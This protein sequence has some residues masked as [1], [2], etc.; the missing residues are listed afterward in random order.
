MGLA[1]TPISLQGA[2]RSF[3]RSAGILRLRPSRWHV[4][5]PALYAAITC[6]LLWPLVAH[7]GSAVADTIG[8]P[9]LNAWTLRW[10]QHAVL[11]DPLRLY[12]GNM[13][14]PNLRSLAFSELL[15]PQAI[16][17]WPIW[18]ITQ[19]V[20]IAYNI[21]V[22]ITYP[23]CAIG[24][25]AL[26]RGLG[27]NRG[28]AFVAG[29]CFSFAPFRLDNNAHLQVLSMQWMPLALLAVVRFMQRPT[30]WR[31]AAVTIS[32]ALTSLSSVYYAMMFGTGLAVFLIIEA[33]RQRRL[34]VSRR[35]LG[36]LAALTIAVA[37]VGALD[38]PY[39]VMRREQQITRTLDEAYDESAHTGS[40]LTVTPGNVAWRH[41]LPR[42]GAEHTALF[43][44]GV[45]LFFAIVG[46]R[47]LRRPWFA[48][49]LG[50]GAAC[51]VLSFG[52]TLG[53]KDAGIPLPYRLLYEYVAGFQGI[54][55]P[56]RF[57]ALVLLALGVF[58][59]IG[60]TALWEAIERRRPAVRRLGVLVAVL[61]AAL[62]VSDCAARLLPTVPV[63]L[64]DATLAPYRWL[65]SQPNTGTVAEFPVESE[66]FRTAFYS[67]YHWHPLL[68]GH[69][70]FVPR[71]TYQLRERFIKGP[72]YPTP[73]SLDAL[74]DFGV[75]TL[76][77][78]RSEYPA[79]VLQAM[80][81]SLAKSP[82]RVALV[83]R[84]G[85][86][87]IYMLTPDPSAEALAVQGILRVNPNG[88]SDK[89]PGILTIDN[90]G[91]GIRMLYVRGYFSIAAEVRD[92]S[93]R[94]LAD[95]PVVI[96]LPGFVP[97][98]RTAVPF[99]VALPRAPGT[100]TIALRSKSVPLV[101]NDTP[102]TVRVLALGEL[103]RLTLNGQT[104]TSTPLYTP[105]EAVALW[106]TLKDGRTVPLPETAARPDGSIAANIGA[107]PPNTS[108]LVAHG[109]ISGVEMWV[110]P[111]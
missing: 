23:L 100:Y 68:W 60:V 66:E 47:A 28:G 7:V 39:L 19:N 21:S 107:F 97:S 98:G 102:D 82:E 91:G 61:V 27:A 14:A 74:I 89:V 54:R 43:P 84:E 41:I 33:M 49:L 62:V 69:S 52:P 36:L 35:A 96:D 25:Y 75:R 18:L 26:C 45:L 105:G 29:L 44:G 10:V 59:A 83:A 42:S 63:S 104:L 88:N 9:L 40:Y 57:A 3:F 38:V 22:L 46:F 58:A 5:V 56:V 71:P 16:L 95:Q 53:A 76:I 48:G 81:Q 24:M 110:S 50:L 93:G 1:T 30:R 64:S 106:A 2:H 101:N 37:I 11:T 85:D 86:A 6:V 87:D 99:S 15:L 13:F 80:T 92:A 90:A 72:D 12:D 78:H 55:G 103:P 20:L 4:L 77:V 31:F 8:D 79:D 108:L 65:A 111:P 51:F 34:F 17:A 73:D 67:T 32:V 70:G 109:K 94:R